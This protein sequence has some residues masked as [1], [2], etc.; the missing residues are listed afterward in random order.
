MLSAN[1]PLQQPIS[2]DLAQELD[3]CQ[4][5]L[6]D[7]VEAIQLFNYKNAYNEMSRIYTRLR[8]VQRRLDFIKTN[9]HEQVQ[10]IEQLNEVANRGMGVLKGLDIAKYRHHRVNW[11]VGR[12]WTSQFPF[13]LVCPRFNRK[14]LPE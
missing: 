3:I 8:H 11:K 4:D 6:T 7:L 9:T 14:E 10:L 5:I 12:C 2:L 1:L 13:H